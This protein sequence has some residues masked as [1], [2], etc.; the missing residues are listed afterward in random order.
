ML[1]TPF[2]WL[3]IKCQSKR[4]KDNFQIPAVQEKEKR[5]PL[6]TILNLHVSDTAKEG[7]HCKA[8]PTMIERFMTACARLA[9]QK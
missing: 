4:I 3:Q 8:N 7:K 6:I 1:L 5:G 9:A 2:H